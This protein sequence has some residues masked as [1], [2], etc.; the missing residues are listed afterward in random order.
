MPTT[1]AQKAEAAQLRQENLQHVLDEI[2]ELP[3]SSPLR[4]YVTEN[5]IHSVQDFIMLERDELEKVTVSKVVIIKDESG[6]DIQTVAALP[7]SPFDIRRILILRSYAEYLGSSQYDSSAQIQWKAHTMD[8]YDAFRIGPYYQPTSTHPLPV[9]T[10]TQ[11]SHLNSND[12]VVQ[13]KKGIKRDPTVFPTFKQEK[14]WDSFHRSVLAHAENQDV[15]S[16][17]RDDWHPTPDNEALD[18]QKQIYM[19]SVFDTVLKTSY[20]LKLVHQ[21]DGHPQRATLIWRA[22]CE[23]AKVS[24]QATLNADALILYICTADIRTWRGTACD[25][26]LNWEEQVR[27]YHEH[28]GDAAALH[29]TV[30][31]RLLRKAVQSIPALKNVEDTCEIVRHS[32][33]TNTERDYEEYKT[34]LFSACTTYDA[35]QSLNAGKRQRPGFRRG[36]VH[37]RSNDDQFDSAT[38]VHT[39]L[40]YRHFVMPESEEMLNGDLFFESPD[41]YYMNNRLS[42][43]LT[44]QQCRD[45]GPDMLAV[46][47]KLTPE[48]KRIITGSQGNR[49]NFTGKPFS[50]TGKAGDRNASMHDVENSMQPLSVGRELSP[51]DISVT[52]QPTDSDYS[53]EVNAAET[54]D[55]SVHPASLAQ[56]LGPDK[57]SRALLQQTK[58]QD[59]TQDK[60]QVKI[61]GKNPKIQDKSVTFA[62]NT[63]HLA[64]HMTRVQPSWSTE[65]TTTYRCGQLKGNFQ[66]FGSLVDRGANGGVAGSDVRLVSWTL[67]R[68]NVTG[69]QNH[70]MPNLKVGT[71]GGVTK[72]QRGHV[73]LILNQYAY[74][75]EGKTIHSSGQLEWY[76][77]KVDDRSTHVGGHQHI[78]TN[79]GYLLP[80]NIVDGLPYLR[81]RPFT[82]R[83]YEA[84][85]H[86]IMTSDDLWDPKVLDNVID[87]GPEWFD[88]Q[89][90][91]PDGTI[92]K[93]PFDEYG[94]YTDIVVEHHFSDA[95]LNDKIDPDVSEEQKVEDDIDYC[96]LTSLAKKQESSSKTSTV[97]VNGNTI[98]LVVDVTGKSSESSQAEFARESEPSLE[99]V[100]APVDAPPPE[101][102]HPPEPPL[103]PGGTS[104]GS[105][106]AEP[107]VTTSKAP[108]WEKMRKFFLWVPSKTVEKTFGATTQY[109]RYPQSD[110]LRKMFKSPF[111]ACN[112]SRRR[113]S[114]ATDTIYSDT[115]AIFGGET[116]AQLF[117][118]RESLV[119]DVYGMKTS[120]QFANTLQD[121]IRQRGAMDKLLSDRAQVEVSNRVLDIL[122]A[123]S[124]SDWQSEPYHQHQNF[125]E[126][127]YKMVKDC[128]NRIMDREGA[129]ADTWL[130]A[131]QYT[132]YILN[133]TAHETL[134][135]RTPL[136]ALLGQSPDI[137]ELLRF[138]F[139]QPVFYSIDAEEPDGHSF[140]SKSEE[141]FGHFVGFAESVGNVMCVKILTNDTL[142]IIYRSRVR[143]AGKDY[144]PNKRAAPHI[145]PDSGEKYPL[146]IKSSTEKRD[147]I[148]IESDLLDLT[149]RSFLME[150]GE[151]GQR[152]RCEV[153]HKIE[154]YDKTLGDSKDRQRFVVSINDGE[155]E[156]VL[157][158]REILDHV[159]ADA[160][161][162][163]V[164]RF[165]SIIA[166]Q[167]PLSSTS[168]D[169]KGS[170]WNVLVLWETGEQTYE[171]LSIVAADDPVTCAVYAR[172]HGL[173][174]LDGW[175]RFRRIAKRQKVL[176]R[177]VH[178]SSLRSARSAK[179]YK[180][181]FEVP[182]THDQAVA[183]DERNK[184]TKWQDAEKLEIQQLRDYECFIDKG[185]GARIPLGYKKIRVHIVYDVK[186]DGR[187]KAR[188]V[189]GGHLTDAPIESVYSGVVSLRG[190]RMVLFLAELNGLTTF[191]TDIGNAYLEAY[192]SEKV[193][194][195][196]GPEFGDL[197]GHTLVI[198]K[199]LY[200]LRTSG[201]RWAETFSETLMELGFTPSKAEP[202]IWMRRNGDIYEYI[203]VYVD[204]LCL[205]MKNP[206]AFCDT[207]MNTYKY[208]LKGTGPISFHLGCDFFRDEEGVLCMAPKK[209]IDKMMS[210]YERMFGEK[211]RTTYTS[212]LEKGDHPELDTSELLDADG[213]KKY[214]SMIGAMQ[215]A[216]SLGRIDI[217]TAVMTLSG[218]RV[219]P[220][221]G[222]LER[223]KRV[224]GFLTHFRESTVRFLTEEPD[225]S[226]LPEPLHDWDYSVYG[227]VHEMVPNDC[228]EPL[229]RYVTT[230]TYVDANL[231][232][233]ML[234]GRSVTGILHMLNRT[235]VDWYSKKQATVETATYG[236][237]FVAARIATEQI[238]DLR[239]TLRYLGVPIREY[240][241]MFGDNSSVVTSATIPHSKLSKRHM[242]LSYHRVREAIASKMLRFYFIDG[243]LNPADILSKHWGYQAVKNLLKY[244]LLNV[245]PST[246]KS[247]GSDT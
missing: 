53:L 28:S 200:G 111:P 86:V 31:S 36:N 239:T 172:K 4:T 138:H 153:V 7:L 29:V 135:W 193:A 104:K 245:R 35:S 215:W 15:G 115:P 184:N 61:Q 203:A 55:R 40:A 124:I 207:L 119:T 139:Y 189:A 145:D 164:W 117:V 198:S 75:G 131:V 222:H 65:T 34:L 147:M 224:Y 51:S 47:D 110:A 149:G 21:Y 175:K 56:L 220:R 113:E 50:S 188:C 108:D 121:V 228:P 33:T 46:W 217:T 39:L 88:S 52:H 133:R 173:L 235:P 72:T 49:A 6:A 211:P 165:K 127:R 74:S 187:H 60:T 167:G 44:Q 221:Q 95:F 216:V 191:C 71:F 3:E 236:S 227:K 9:P 163:P 106:T 225:F 68:V 137:S 100:D 23:R 210:G 97:L 161:D 11:S 186:H 155:Y 247:K 2:L 169:Y 54:T 128:T 5:D 213:I 57:N 148:T 30:L 218:Y 192:T 190:L 22:L 102:P 73:V 180:Y 1:R 66:S 48:A 154:E 214:Q 130:L 101:P 96:V 241:Y 122:R 129:P 81:I 226:D 91:N 10:H 229:G 25:F 32:V 45:L 99:R 146:F 168:P 78:K 90:D 243:P 126:N 27:L 212:P 206:Q 140:S 87:E 170:K 112:V 179:V 194:I 219:A 185:L 77:N 58:A 195:I 152:F 76:K 199:A 92:D 202:T 67:H 26:L 233:D 98:E 64:L 150:E 38:D 157:T 196:A 20:G 103:D 158:Y 201:K 83:E 208:K 14:E 42:I 70:Q 132:C 84:L 237:E 82:D 183:I 8:E 62:S 159:E 142:K 85:P 178:Q 244:L 242:A 16:I 246:V 19:F 197:Q 151:D 13:F 114:V 37:Q 223:A 205:A 141:A 144:S 240:S 17:L 181:G 230:I 79:D 63:H 24:T 204:D 238:V 177:M 116:M 69:I 160:R 59:K 134:D 43:N 182:R 89:S 174:H 166:H 94:D 123:Y 162:E 93:A 209:Y 18:T 107:K 109:A 12:P 234:T 80:L 125:A 136:E 118:G 171:P 143:P 232:H 231:Y 120:K 176:N 105:I 156:D 41:E